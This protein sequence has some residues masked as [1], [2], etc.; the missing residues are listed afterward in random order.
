MRRICNECKEECPLPKDLIESL[1][2]G[3]ELLHEATIYHGK[4]CDKC[5]KSGYSGRA[6]IYEMLTMTDE[7][8]RLIIRG[9][10][11]V[12]LK[13][14]ARIRGMS[15]LRESGLQLVKNG[16]TTLQEV[17]AITNDDEVAAQEGG[18][19]TPLA[20]AVPAAAPVGAE[21]PQPT[22]AVA[23]PEPADAVEPPATETQGQPGSVE[24]LAAANGE[25]QLELSDKAREIAER[26]QTGN[27]EQ[28]TQVN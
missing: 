25:Q 12:E 10:P 14:M 24:S 7:L 15:T 26:W 22:Q 6:P 19:V 27:E 21:T 23:E 8:R 13:E 16:V 3:A 5:N 20:V 9:A 18:S 2:V 17:M 28:S 1:G 11:T 4:G